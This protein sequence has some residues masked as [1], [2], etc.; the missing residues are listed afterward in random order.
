MFFLWCARVFGALQ[1]FAPEAG[2]HLP[3]LP[4]SLVAICLAF[5]LVANSAGRV[6]GGF[7][8][9]NPAL[10]EKIAGRGVTA[11][12]SVVRLL[13]LEPGGSFAPLGVPSLFGVM[14]PAWSMTGPARDLLVRRATP[15]NIWGRVY[16]VVC[17]GLDIGHAR[18]LSVFGALMEWGPHHSVLLG[19]ALTQD[20]LIT[21]TFNVRRVRRSAQGDH[22]QRG[23]QS[24]FIN[25]I[26]RHAPGC[27]EC[28]CRSSAQTGRR[29]CFGQLSPER[30]G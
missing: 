27:S 5:C 9:A 30:G 20:M 19:L 16:S 13:A 3:A 24:V 21:S 18:W 11:T 10:G 29:C 1:A 25:D 4:P 15:D 2:R 6:A 22:L 14:G 26:Q 7:L 12:A 23:S 17:A 28:C 8:A